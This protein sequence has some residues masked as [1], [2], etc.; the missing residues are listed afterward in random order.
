MLPEIAKARSIA[1]AFVSARQNATALADYPGIEPDS[2]TA[3]IAVQDAAIPLFGDSVAGWKVGRINPPWLEKV[4]VNRLPGPIFAKTIQHIQPDASATGHIF[5]R[6][7]GA[8]E[9]EFIFRL[10]KA[11]AEGGTQLSLSD[12]ADLIDAVFIGIEIASSPFADINIRGPLVTISDFGNNNGLI[13]GAEIPGWRSANLDNW[14]VTASVDGQAVGQGQPSAFPDG[15]L[16]SVKYL[17]EHLISRGIAI[18]P[19]L[20]ISTGA[21]TGVHEITAGQNF[22]A[23]FGDFGKIDCQIAFATA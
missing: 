14:S 18:E 8:A 2:L 1:E 16:G 17:V 11:P 15:L 23:I 22:E 20:L 6:G 12:A 21:V 5:R 7:F 19:G 4:G 3:A 10:G 13:V 9:A